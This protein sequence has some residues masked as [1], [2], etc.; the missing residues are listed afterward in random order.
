MLKS[1]IA[2]LAALVL[3]IVLIG[4]TFSMRPAWWCFFDI[5]FAFMMVFCHLLALQL[6][7]M[8]KAASRKLDTAAMVFGVLTVIALIVEYIV[9]HAF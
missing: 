4:V 1:K 6:V 8:S 5:F 7:K 2:A 3:V 9:L